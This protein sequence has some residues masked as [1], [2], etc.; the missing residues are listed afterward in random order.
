M[1][2]YDEIEKLNNLKKSGA[3]TEEEFEK[4]KEKLLNCEIKKKG[5]GFSIAGL[6]LGIVGTVFGG[7]ISSILGLIFSVK[8]RKQAKENN[9]EDGKAVAGMALSIIGLVKAVLS[10]LLFITIMFL[11]ISEDQ[12]YDYERDRHHRRDCYIY[13]DTTDFDKEEF[14][15]KTENLF[16]INF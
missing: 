15:P 7:L 16:S 14:E 3:I 9:K 2:K 13:E 11:A 4:E 10:I 5:N 1:D 12:M 6:V 8:A